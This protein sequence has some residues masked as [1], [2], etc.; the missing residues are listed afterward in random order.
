MY[1]NYDGKS[2]SPSFEA[3]VEGTV[4][5]SWR[6]PWPEGLARTG[7]YSDLFVFV[8]DGQ[9]DVC[10]YS[11]ATDP[12][13]VGSLQIVQVDPASYDSAT[14]GRDYILVNYGRF[15]CGTD[16][17]GPGF[18][19]DTDL[20][21]RSWQSDSD[22]RLTDVKNPVRV[23]STRFSISG[24]DQSPNYF[25]TK[26]YKTALEV[27]GDGVLEYQLPVD[28]KLDY[29]LWFHFAEIGTGV[30]RARQRVFDILINGKNVNRIDIY[31]EVGSFAAYNWHYSVKNLSST[32][33]NVKL[34]SVSGAALICGLENY[35]L[36][37]ADLSTVPEQGK[38]NLPHS[39]PPYF[40]VWDYFLGFY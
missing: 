14:V 34:V 18:S 20:F 12:P 25:P 29:L 27:G 10:F 9:A 28:A 32:V 33:L 22:F 13:V 7:S 3:S 23:V 17:W 4:V 8:S 36:V 21:G 26:L 2:H 37:P 35:A 5:F 38:G 1:D 19:N 40:W 6:S 16:Q 30:T 11:I 24:T 31:K 39:L 15:T